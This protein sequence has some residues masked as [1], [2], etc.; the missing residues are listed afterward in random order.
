M[1]IN[2]NKQNGESQGPNHGNGLARWL[3]GAMGL[4]WVGGL[5][6][7]A[8]RSGKLKFTEGH[9]ASTAC[10]EPSQLAGI[11][12]RNIRPLPHPIRGHEMRDANTKWIFGVVLFLFVSGLAIHGMLAGFLSL[13]K[14]GPSPKDAWQPS[15]PAKVAGPR[16]VSFPV[17][18]ISAPAELQA[19]RA[20]EEAE[21]HSYGWINRTSGTVRIPIERAMDL[22]LQEGLPTRSSTNANSVGPSSWQLI[23]QRLEHRE[24]KI[25][26]QK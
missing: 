18:Q 8:L 1:A 13:L 22:I 4:L 20:R 21:L 11:G 26:G 3:L 10:A 9:Q 19:F 24:P 16:R 7:R 6:V 15:Q 2:R 5:A 14:S 17:L 23:Q 12:G 25:K